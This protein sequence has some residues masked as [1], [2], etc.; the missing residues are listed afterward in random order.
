M[1]PSRHDPP[2]R[3]IPL[4]LNLSK[5][6]FGLVVR[7]MCALGLFGI[8]FDLEHLESVSIC[9]KKVFCGTIPSFFDTC[10]KPN[11]LVR[12]FSTDT[13][14]SIKLLTLAMRRLFGSFSSRLP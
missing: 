9:G 12:L 14:G 8:T 7:A 4:F 3:R 6:A 11:V 5:N 2:L 10:H 13:T 1:R